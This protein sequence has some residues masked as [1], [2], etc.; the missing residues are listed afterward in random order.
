MYIYNNKIYKDKTKINDKYHMSTN[1][2]SEGGKLLDKNDNIIINKC[3]LYYEEPLEDIIT[4]YSIK[5]SILYLKG[6]EIT[7]NTILKV[8]DYIATYDY[9]ENET[10][11]KI[12]DKNG[13]EKYRRLYSL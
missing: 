9:K 1:D 10:I 3:M 13:N 4:G 11:Y 12:Y 2:C 7:T 8:G 5:E 6:K